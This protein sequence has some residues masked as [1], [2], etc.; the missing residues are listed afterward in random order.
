MSGCGIGVLTAPT[1][2]LAWWQVVYSEREVPVDRV[3]VSEVVKVVLKEVPVEV[4][5][6][7]IREVVKEVPVQVVKEVV[8]E[9]PVEVVREVVKEVVKEV[10]VEKIVVK[11]VE[12]VPPPTPTP[13]HPLQGPPLPVRRCFGRFNTHGPDCIL[14]HLEKAPP[15]CVQLPAH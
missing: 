12:K 14:G 3:A 5:K 7:V 6:E 11:E 15:P 8:R 13:P 9:V 10:P 4:V 1:H 2:P